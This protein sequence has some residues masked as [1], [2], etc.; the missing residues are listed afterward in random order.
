MTRCNATT[1]RGRPCPVAIPDGQTYCATHAGHIPVHVRYDAALT[2]YRRLRETCA[3]DD[4]LVQR[5]LMRVH[6]AAAA[7]DRVARVARGEL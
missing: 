3:V 6:H 4:P 2:E 1:R 7:S 5:A